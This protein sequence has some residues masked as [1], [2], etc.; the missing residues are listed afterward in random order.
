MSSDFSSIETRVKGRS[1]HR[2]SVTIAIPFY[3]PGSAFE[4]A[5][6]SVFAQ[7]FTDWELLLLDDGGSDGSMELVRR[8]NDPRVVIHSDGEQHGL[9]RRL[10]NAAALARGEYLFRMDADDLMHPERVAEQLAVLC[11]S[12]PNTVVGSSAYSIDA[13]TAVVGY[14]PA[15]KTQQR[16]YAA[17]YSFLH[18]TV[19]ASTAWFRENPYSAEPIFRRCEDAELWCRSTGHSVFRWIERPLMFYREVGVFKLSNYIAGVEGLIEINRRI[20]RDR[21]R[22]MK[23]I[24]S[25]RMKMGI[26]WALDT[27]GAADVMVRN[28]FRPIG[29]AGFAKASE[30][31]ETIAKTSLPL[32]GR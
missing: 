29:S 12:P 18:P 25:E 11:A 21:M 10:N 9:S 20:E 5:L 17:R 6:K 31:V 16:G 1:A 27:L 24:A 32:I 15:P 3:N 4:L 2:P 8:L 23:V 14:R 30:V 26:A 22:R 28:R 19:A 7:T 13:G